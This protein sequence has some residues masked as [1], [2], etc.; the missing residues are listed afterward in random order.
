LGSASDN[1]GCRISSYVK[2]LKISS[3]VSI[4]WL[5]VCHAMNLYF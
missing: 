2:S 3:L 1:W 5:K 4:S